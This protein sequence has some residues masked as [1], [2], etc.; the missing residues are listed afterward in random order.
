MRHAESIKEK[1]TKIEVLL[2]LEKETTIEELLDLSVKYFKN[3]YDG[4][5]KKKRGKGKRSKASSP[6][7]ERI[8]QNK[9]RMKV[10]QTSRNSLIEVASDDIYLSK[11]FSPDDYMFSEATSIKKSCDV[12]FDSIPT[13]LESR[14]SN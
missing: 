12:C 3:K 6:K 13:I 1:E 10:D 7:A 14:T 9:K 11:I 5:K 8:H 4:E 2:D